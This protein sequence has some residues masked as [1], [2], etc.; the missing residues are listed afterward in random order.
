MSQPPHLRTLGELRKEGRSARTL[1]EEIRANLLRKLRG[2]EQLF[3]GI[4]GY[5][6][7]VIVHEVRESD[8]TNVG[9]NAHT[10]EVCDLF[11]DGIID[12][13]KVVRCALQNAASVSG[14][15]LTT[16]TLITDL[17]DKNDEIEGAVI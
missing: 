2:G 8:D 12:P 14:L 17:S 11:K 6:G 9:F 7:S 5:D 13:A 4:L 16:D 3:P 10:G 15:M 1:R